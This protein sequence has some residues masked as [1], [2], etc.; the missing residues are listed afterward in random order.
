MEQIKI[1]GFAGSLR[2]GSYNRGLIRAAVELAPPGT[3]VE[4]FELGDIPLYNQDIEDLGDPP[5]V[6]AFKKAL[7]GAD[8]LLVA[9]PEYNHCIPGVLK[10]ALDWA[11]RPRVT[12][13][14]R[15]KPVAILGASSGP[16][17]TARAQANLR[18]AFVFVG[19]VVMPL[20]EVLVARATDHFDANGNLTD[21]EIG[22]SI[23]ELI[24]ALAL[25]TARVSGDRAA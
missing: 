10:N 25:W 24:H 12:S 19:A 5:A 6:G 23:L 17:A 2:R 9:T 4:M 7:A 14:L 1:L 13:P 8:A 16:G 3:A 18:E 15:D 21:P 20:P 11:S 22:A